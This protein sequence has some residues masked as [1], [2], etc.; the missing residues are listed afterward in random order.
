MSTGG[1]RP[2]L[3]DCANKVGICLPASTESLTNQ[4]SSASNSIMFKCCRC[5]GTALCYNPLP[6][7]KNV[8]FLMS[9]HLQNCPRSPLNG[10]IYSLQ[11]PTEAERGSSGGGGWL[12]LDL[13]CVHTMHCCSTAAT[14][15]TRVECAIP[16]TVQ[17]A[18][19]LC[20][21]PNGPLYFVLSSVRTDDALEDKVAWIRKMW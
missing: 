14:T 3:P 12:E 9:Q 6:S 17:C 4:P 7:R 8:A 11:N 19:F 15:H 18:S 5:E 2:S 1:Q 13:P 20:E 21:A 16:T 10:S